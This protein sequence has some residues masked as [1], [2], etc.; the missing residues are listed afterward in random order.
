MRAT[1][2]PAAAARRQ[3]GAA[4]AGVERA[5]EMLERAER[6]RLDGAR[7]LAVGP[8]AGDDEPAVR[9]GDRGHAREDVGAA[10]A[11]GLERGAVQPR[12]GRVAADAARSACPR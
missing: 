8:A 1:V 9:A 12:G 3:R 2:R 4:G 11:D 10:R 6:A 7:G 5:A